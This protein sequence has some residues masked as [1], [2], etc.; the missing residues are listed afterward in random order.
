MK[1]ATKT[2]QADVARGVNHGNT[3]DWRYQSF[4]T[5]KLMG[6]YSNLSIK[7]NPELESNETEAPAE[8]AS[9]KKSELEP[10]NLKITGSDAAAK[11]NSNEP[12][13]NST[14]IKK[15]LKGAELLLVAKKL[16][17]VMGFDRDKW[18]YEKLCRAILENCNS[19]RNVKVGFMDKGT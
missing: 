18:R 8:S 10:L 13:L 9:C 5:T 16:L 12:A 3:S 6:T 11:T 2:V 14:V 4:S 19:D 17:F 15:N 1:Q 7:S